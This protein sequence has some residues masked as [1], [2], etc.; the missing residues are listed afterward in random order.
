MALTS[1][2][3]LELWDLRT[4]QRLLA[5]PIG[6]CLA[7]FD[8]AGRLIIG[9]SKGI[10]RLPR[11]IEILTGSAPH[12]ESTEKPSARRSLVRFGPPERLNGSIVPTSMA[13]NASG[14]TVVFEDGIGWALLPLGGNSAS[15]RLPTKHDP[16][17]SAV[18]ND[19]R[20]VAIANW[21]SGGVGIWD[22]T[23][24]A[25]LADLTV[26]PHGV[27]QFSPDG[28]LLAASPDGVTLWRTSDWQRINELA[29]ARNHADGFGNGV[30]AR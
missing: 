12:V 1:D 20:Y 30:L 7:D 8:S 15:T 28:R 27:V 14:A 13:L 24:G 21:E 4:T 6:H 29:R 22:G 2:G 23:S 5:W 17:K 10:F 9:H 18:S 19:N 26:G 25:H 16:R 11:Q 3:G